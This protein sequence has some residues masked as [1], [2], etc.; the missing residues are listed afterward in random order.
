MSTIQLH[1][2]TSVVDR[3]RNVTIVQ[4]LSV[5]QDMRLTSITLKR[6]LSGT[7]NERYSARVYDS[8]GALIGAG[9][10]TFVNASKVRLLKKAAEHFIFEY[11]WKYDIRFDIISILIQGQ[12]KH[13]IHHIEDAFY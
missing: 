12:N 13:S 2:G 5:A 9:P 1:A 8:S 7:I 10:E 6:S 3:G 11:D 4:R